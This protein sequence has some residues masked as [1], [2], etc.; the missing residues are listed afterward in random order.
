MTSTPARR[1]AAAEDDKQEA[2]LAA[3]LKLFAE[4]G[5]H[6]TA[7]PLVAE[8]ARVGTGTVYR[9]FDSKEALVNALYRRWKERMMRAFTEG[10]PTGRFSRA[11]FSEM[12]RRMMAFA[13]ENP[14]AMFFLDLHHHG[15]YLDAR[16][17][18]LE[19]QSWTWMRDLVESAQ[20]DGVLAP[21]QPEV[22]ISLVYGG[23]LNIL[24][25]AWEGRY[26]LT[27]A[28]VQQAE[29]CIWKAIAA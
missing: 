1:R 13:T 27:P 28:L 29:D 4:R 25:N 18:A 20:R 19:A 10:F 9:Y 5:F 3:A 22:V 21:L 2:V 11:H 15:D 12:W 16:S 23:F 14:D 6:G 26:R 8:T 24:Q 17:R 7:V